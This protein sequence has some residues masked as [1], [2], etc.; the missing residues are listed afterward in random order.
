MLDSLILDIRYGLRRC[1]R[2]PAFSAAAILT[3]GL[4]V[5]LTTAIFSVGHAVLL[6]PLPYAEPGRLV[7]VG[8]GDAGTI[9]PLAI[10]DG[11]YLAWRE[12]RLH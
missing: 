5:G 4:A 6:K 1:R 3:I 12:Q 9:H 2:E 8:Q 10:G 11:Q 7:V